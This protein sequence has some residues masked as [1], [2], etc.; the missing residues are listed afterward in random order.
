[1][2][3]ERPPISDS[4]MELESLEE[5]TPVESTPVEAT[6]IGATPIKD[7]C[8]EESGGDALPMEEASEEAGM[9]LVQRACKVSN[10]YQ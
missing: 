2:V 1:M 4:R 5:A 6:P 8:V 7:V 10:P 3:I 9:S